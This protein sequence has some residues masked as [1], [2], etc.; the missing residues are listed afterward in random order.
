MR[1]DPKI[2]DALCLL[3]LSVVGSTPWSNRFEL[4]QFEQFFQLRGEY[5]SLAV[6]FQHPK[7]THEVDRQIVGSLFREQLESIGDE[8][9]GLRLGDR[10]S[11]NLKQSGLDLLVLFRF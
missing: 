8:L 4:G 2:R 9:N 7:D 3:A 11:Q 1:E 10:K 5:L 6:L